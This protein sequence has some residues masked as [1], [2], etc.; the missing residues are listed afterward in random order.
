MR[1]NIIWFTAAIAVMFALGGC[2]SDTVSIVDDSKEV[3]YLQSY[4]DATDR[5]D[6]VANV[7]YECGDDIVGYTDAQ[8]AFVFYN[9]EACTFY[10]LDDTVSYEHNR[11]YLSA[12]ASGSKAVA[13]VTYRCASGWHGI[14]DAEGRFIFDPNYYSNVSDGDMCKLYL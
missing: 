10:D 7:Y 12:T 4:D 2:G 14:T 6:G 1:K 13:N 9:G 5:F 8:G 3:F 11:L